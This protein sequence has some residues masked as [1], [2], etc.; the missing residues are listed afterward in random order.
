MIF[1]VRRGEKIETIGETELIERALKIDS[2][3][4]FLE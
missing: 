2:G 3:V 4:T 1:L